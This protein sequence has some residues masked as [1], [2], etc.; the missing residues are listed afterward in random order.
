M[1]NLETILS[2]V[3]N[4]EELMNKIKNTVKKNDDNS[5]SSLDEVISLIAPKLNTKNDNNTES[6]TKTNNSESIDINSSLSFVSSIS[7]TISKNSGL[8][9]A[10][11]PYLSKERCQIIDS[12]V[13]LSQIADTLKLL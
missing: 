8:L 5:S 6:S 4:D 1:D 3:M 9:L 7:N 2:S 13:K 10:L 11:K 12:V